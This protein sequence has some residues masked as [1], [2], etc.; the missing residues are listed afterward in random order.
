[1][2]TLSPDEEQSSPA[3]P[4][5]KPPGEYPTLD[6]CIAALNAMRAVMGDDCQQVYIRIAR[7]KH[8]FETGTQAPDPEQIYISVE[9]DHS[10]KQMMT[11]LEA[12]TINESLAHILAQN[13]PAGLRVEAMNLRAK[14]ED[15]ER[16]ANEREAQNFSL[17]T[18]NFSP[19]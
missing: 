6:Q 5:P 12:P 9:C 8:H 4:A 11:G 17:E 2:Q 18:E 14:A 10:V 19:V 7:G 3:T 15:L 13:T 16:I 1:M